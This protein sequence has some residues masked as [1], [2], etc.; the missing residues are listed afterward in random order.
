MSFEFFFLLLI[1][2][3]VQDD[4][5]ELWREGGRE[6]LKDGRGREA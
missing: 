6:R 2:V 3:R 1:Y 4:E 5:R